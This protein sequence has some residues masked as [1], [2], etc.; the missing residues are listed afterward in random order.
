MTAFSVIGQLKQYAKTT[1]LKNSSNSS[2]VIVFTNR[3][4]NNNSNKKQISALQTPWASNPG[5]K[6]VPD[7]WRDPGVACGFAS[8]FTDE[9]LARALHTFKMRRLEVNGEIIRDLRVTVALIGRNLSKELLQQTT[10]NTHRGITQAPLKAASEVSLDKW[11]WWPTGVLMQ[12]IKQK[13]KSAGA[14]ACLC[15]DFTGRHHYRSLSIRTRVE[16]HLCVL[17]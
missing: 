3:G 12:Q 10:G 16:S 9:V 8:V 2:L 13:I 4:V 17:Y 11:T 15:F 7:F 6:R 1:P 14:K 5:V